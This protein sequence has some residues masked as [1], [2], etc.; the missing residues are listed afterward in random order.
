MPKKLEISY[1]YLDL[2]YEKYPA[3]PSQ[4]EFAAR[5]KIS[6]NYARKVIIE[7]T[8]TGSLTDPEVTNSDRIREKEKVLYLDPAKELFMLALCAKKPETKHRLRGTA[9]YLLWY[10]GFSFFHLALVQ[11]KVRP[12]RFFTKAESCASRQVSARKCNPVRQIQVEVQTTV[13]SLTILFP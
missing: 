12:Q 9:V 11:N 10:H 2:G 1:L 8:N 6:T 5:A 13:R 4:R 7:L 3:R